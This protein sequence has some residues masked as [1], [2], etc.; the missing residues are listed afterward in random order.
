MQMLIDKLD[1]QWFSI[2]LAERI[3]KL[4]KAKNRLRAI[5]SQKSEPKPETIE[6]HIAAGDGAFTNLKA[7]LDAYFKNKELQNTFC[8]Y[9]EDTETFWCETD[10]YRHMEYQQY[11]MNDYFD[12]KA[13]ALKRIKKEKKLT[14]FDLFSNNQPS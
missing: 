12:I 1:H 10:T 7:F 11:R 14:I 13:K 3:K 6:K 9:F 8:I 4:D 2:D 5:G